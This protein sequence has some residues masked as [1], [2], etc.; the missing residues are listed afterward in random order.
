MHGLVVRFGCW[1]TA[2]QSSLELLESSRQTAWNSVYWGCNNCKQIYSTHAVKTN[3]IV[4]ICTH[5]DIEQLQFACYDVWYILYNTHCPV[6][7][8]LT[9]SIRP[10]IKTTFQQYDNTILEAK[11]QNCAK[12]L[13]IFTYV[14]QLKKYIIGNDQSIK[15]NDQK[16]LNHGRI[17]ANHLI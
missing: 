17:S 16:F 15:L 11:D 3:N 12:T 9:E 10:Y 4:L 8:L 5:C 1:E 2:I 13:H 6:S 7:M 14:I